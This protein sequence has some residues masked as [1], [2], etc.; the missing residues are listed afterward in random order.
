MCVL[1][2]F[3]LVDF[4]SRAKGFGFTKGGANGGGANS[5]GGAMQALAPG[6]WRPSGR[7]WFQGVVPVLHS[8]S[9]AIVLHL[10]MGLV[11]VEGVVAAVYKAK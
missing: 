11:V 9:L 7:H 2:C 6:R 10:V 5:E 8:P 1:F 3:L 4:C